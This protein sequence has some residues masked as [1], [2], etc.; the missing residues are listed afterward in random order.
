MT[1]EACLEGTELPFSFSMAFQPIVDLSSRSIFAYEALVRGPDG[2]SAASVLGQVDAG[3]RYA[4][5]QACRVKAI[6]LAARLGLPA[7]SAKLSINFMPAAVY[8]PENC[9][10]TTLRT[11]RR[12][13][14]PLDR[15]M[16]EVTENEPVQDPAHLLGIFQ[17]YQ[18][19]GFISAIDDFGAGYAGLNLLAKFQPQVI[20]LDMELTRDIH[21]R[22]VARTIVSAILQV[23]RTLNIT[24]IAEG[25]ET[26]AELQALRDMGMTL[27]QG[28]LFARPGFEALPMPVGL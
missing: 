25:V 12:V 27:F 15:L 23:C 24:T 26:E 17:E 6:E 7:T 5:D 9:L 10:R 14:M 21:E 22:F 20:K 11:S 13:G 1:C 19:Q 3:N 16:F 8:R 18:R 2:Q 4:F 28:Y